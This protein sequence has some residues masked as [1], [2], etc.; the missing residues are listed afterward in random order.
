MV[1]QRAENLADLK[2]E[3]IEIH[4]MAMTIGAEIT[5]A[6]LTKPLSEKQRDEINAALLKWKVLFFRAQHMNH[7]Q[8]IAFS[9]QFGECTTA[10]P[11][12]GG[13]TEEYPEIYTIDRD[14][15]N[16]RYK[17]ADVIHPWTG[18]HADVTPAINPPKISILRGEQMPPY[19]GDTQFADMVLAY[20]ALSETMRNFIDGLRC[21]HRYQGN[22]A[23]GI[24]KEYL[25]T[26]NRTLLI[27]EH[28]MVRIHPETGEKVLYV[29]PGFVE[30]IVDLTPTES[31]ALL[32]LL[33]THAARPEFN[34][35][36]RWG[37]GDVAMW[38]NRQT[39]HRGP[40]D[41]INTDF[42]RVIHRTT[43]IGDIP[44]GPD[45][46]KSV[47]IEGKPMEPIPPR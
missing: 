29:V 35:R 4:P 3:T 47:S 10:H 32:A 24:N 40:K 33:K 1:A 9:R 41:V 39:V 28:P 38:D 5:G 42:P 13:G 14:R 30:S 37:S 45:G 18:W 27:S 22:A 16:K 11:V 19:G 26:I 17:G 12:Y 36:F 8:H 31:Q 44:Y 15:R 25:E 23:V 6:D 46:R 21:I 20:Y 43:L 7:D 34:V 2:P